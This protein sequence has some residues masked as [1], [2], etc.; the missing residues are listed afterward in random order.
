LTF[1]PS[2]LASP[3]EPPP[4]IARW[5]FPDEWIVGLILPDRPTFSGEKESSFFSEKTPLPND[6]VLLTMSAVYHGVLPAFAMTDLALLKRA[7]EKIHSTGL[8]H[9]ELHAQTQRTIDIFHRF[10]SLPRTA[11]GLS[12]LG[13]LIYCI[14]HRYDSGTREALEELA[15]QN[16]VEFLG[17]FSGYNSAF[18]VET[19]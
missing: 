2:S 10:Q 9:E 19:A 7:L 11:I 4:L 5:T 1:S 17:L 15:R 18:E 12:S 3:S 8:K 6:Q 14:F 16:E 13:P